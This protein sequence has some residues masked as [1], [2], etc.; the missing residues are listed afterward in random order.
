[1]KRTS[2]RSVS[3]A[4]VAL[5]AVATACSDARN[6]LTPKLEAWPQPPAPQTVELSGAGTIVDV[7]D[8]GFITFTFDVTSDATGVHGRFSAADTHGNT[9]NGTSFGPFRPSSSFCGTA[10]NGAEFDAVGPFLDGGVLSTTGFT[11]KAC[12]NGPPPNGGDTFFVHI[13]SN[14]FEAS[15][16]LL[17]GGDIQKQVR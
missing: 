10:S 15:G 8:G 5:L 17:P 7:P 14:G 13:N 16:T 4:A 3:A 12:D 6:P 1:M 2:S 11:V 9:L